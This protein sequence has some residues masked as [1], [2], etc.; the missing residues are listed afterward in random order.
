MKEAG[1]E[2]LSFELLNP[3]VDQP[4]KYVAIWL[5]DEWSKIGLHMTP[6]VVPTSPWFDT[7]YVAAPDQGLPAYFLFGTENEPPPNS[8]QKFLAN[9]CFAGRGARIQ[10]STSFRPFLSGPPAS[11]C[12]RATHRCLAT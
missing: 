1:A 5:I 3:T 10:Q 4:F 2:G 8:Q 12:T 7:L 11:L 6:R 9:W